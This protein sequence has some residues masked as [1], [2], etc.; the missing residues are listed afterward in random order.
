MRASFLIELFLFGNT[1]TV[2]I[3]D[4][5]CMTHYSVNILVKL[6][7]LTKGNVGESVRLLP[8][9]AGYVP[10]MFIIWLFF[11][12]QYMNGT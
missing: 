1:C 4:D 7:I 8:I 6:F 2:F 12:Y 5:R 3:V 11:D 10:K 9:Y